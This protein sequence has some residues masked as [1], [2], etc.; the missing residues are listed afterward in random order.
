[1]KIV[2]LAVFGV[3]VAVVVSAW[4]SILWMPGRASR[5]PLPHDVPDCVVDLRRDLKT[6]ATDIG[7]RNVSH[8]YPQL[9]E[10]AQF[11]E[12]SLREAGYDVGRQEFFV[13]GKAVWNVSA[14][15]RGTVRADEIIIVG[16]HY[17]TVPGSP[18]AN[19]NGSAVV[20]NLALARAFAKKQTERTLRFLFFVNEEFPYYMTPDMG[21]LRYAE[22]CRAHNEQIVGMIALETIGYYTNAPR[23]QRYPVNLLKY[24]YPTSGHFVA[25]VGNRRSRRWVHQV[26]RAFRRTRFPSEGIAAPSWLRD[27]FRSDHAPFWRCGYPALMVTDTAN[28]RYPHYHTREDTPDKVQFAAL[29]QV[30]VGLERALRELASR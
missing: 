29:A 5:G 11:L 14:E 16:A 26:V 3:L 22:H 20:A 30:V 13:A 17:D 8:D 10:A 25:F 19:D 7:P 6:L 4:R 2:L 27:A 23:S 21:S 1:M 28:F 24:L 15:K 9:L 18:G 12:A